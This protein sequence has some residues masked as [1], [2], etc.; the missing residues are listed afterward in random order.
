MIEKFSLNNKVAL[1]TGA[2][3]GLG[4]AIALG[5]AQA[6]AD[7]AVVDLD[8]SAAEKV[9]AKAHDLGRKAIAIQANVCNANEVKE[10][11][12]SV[13][14]NLGTI[15]ILVNNAGIQRRNPCIEMAEE[16]W[17]AVIE[18]NLK[19]AFLCCKEVGKI[20]V[21]NRRGKVI[22]ITSLL[23]TVA[24]PNRG[25]YAASKGALV[26]LTK[27]LALEWAEYGINVNALA[28][29]YFLT[30]LNKKLMEDKEEFDRLTSKIPMGRW[31]VLEDIVGPAVFLASEASDY[32][33]GHVL[34]V[35]GGYLCM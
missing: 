24:Q 15:D 18:V 8:I 16:D 3:R 23:G 7:I 32:M 33:N 20:M 1:V 25:P 19:G 28:P 6:G 27:V 11:V 26:Q 4:E 2:G 34:Y 14:S 5:Y 30:E 29:G 9:V 22:N 21:N 31:G 17:D 10:M 35:D 12:N 13:I